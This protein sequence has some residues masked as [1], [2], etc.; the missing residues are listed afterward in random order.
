MRTLKLTIAYDGTCYAG[1][2]RQDHVRGKRPP[3]IQ[4]TLEHALSRVLGERVSVVG[5]GRT[6][7]GV[8][9]LGQVAHVRTRSRLAP[10][11]V[12]RATNAFL[13]PDIVVTDVQ[14]VAKAF[15]ARFGVRRKCYRYRLH[16]GPWRW[17]LTR[18]YAHHVTDPLNVPAMRRA[19]CALLGTHE[20]RPFQAAGGRVSDTVRCVTAARW[21]RHGE[22]WW[23]EIAAN[24]FLYKMV[25][26]IVGTLVDVGR[27]RRPPSVIREILDTGNAALVGSTAPA[28]GLTLVSVSY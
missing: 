27:G 22:E 11:V 1:W 8:H 21:R 6:D 13:P 23:F 7:T 9:A 4:A 25:R 10:A 24:G 17:P 19:A 15:H 18:L 14:R 26:R 20:F 5:S 3:T 16:V 2:Q 28:H 12:Q